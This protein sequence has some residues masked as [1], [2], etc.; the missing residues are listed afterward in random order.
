MTL[1]SGSVI[2][3][4][5]EDMRVALAILCVGAVMFLLRV[6]TA[7]VKEW[8][9]SPPNGVRVHFTKFNPS[10]RRGELIEMKP[11]QVRRVSAQSGVRKVV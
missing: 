3:M 11:V 8:M 1:R 7:L 9:S 6:L 5:G 10:L 4:P 2:A